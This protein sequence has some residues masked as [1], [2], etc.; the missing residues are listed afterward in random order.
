LFCTGKD[1]PAFKGK[2]IT[3]IIP[4]QVDTIHQKA[5][6]TITNEQPGIGLIQ[7]DIGT[8]QCRSVI[9]KD[10]AD[11][12]MPDPPVDYNIISYKKDAILVSDN[13]SGIYM[14]N[15]ENGSAHWIAP[16]VK[17][18]SG[19]QTDNDHLIFIRQDITNLTYSLLNGEWKRI[20]SPFDSIAWTGGAIYCSQRDKTYWAGDFNQLIHYDK[21]FRVIHRYTGEDGLNTE[22]IT[23]ILPDDRDDIWIQ[24]VR[25]ILK[26]NI[27]TGK[28]T[29]LSV[30]DGLKKQVYG[31]NTPASTGGDL[32]FWG[33]DGID[34]VS[35]AKLAESYPPSFVYLK[36]LEINQKPFLLP[37]GINDLQELSLRYNQNKIAIETGIIDYYTKG[38]S[39]IRYKLKGLSEKWQVSPA[40]YTIRYDGLPPGEYT[41]EIEASNAA[42]DFNGPKKKA[43]HY[44]PPAFLANMVVQDINGNDFTSDFLWY[45]PLAHGI[46]A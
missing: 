14:V 18:S 1:F 37:T 7:M 43:A 25:S 28:I 13:G 9:F 22:A 46:T 34:R 39:N 12:I 16:G 36:S 38:G 19:L 32:Y 31:P 35:P 40:N 27:K 2:P 23:N 15:T 4:V 26:L 20:V 42:N 29:L 21:D 33:D 8:K 17:K 11:Q 45:L 30:K 24:T 3:Q 44:Y 5:L 10:S 6:F 41:L